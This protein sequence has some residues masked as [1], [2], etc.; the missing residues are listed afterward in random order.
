[1]RVDG[2]LY[3]DLFHR[4]KTFWS[5]ASAASHVLQTDPIPIPGVCNLLI[6][7]RP[8]HVSEQERKRRLSIE[9]GEALCEELHEPRFIRP[10]AIVV[11]SD[12]IVEHTKMAM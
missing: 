1:M 3:R 2:C 6:S 7:L 4:F 10:T 11:Q 9:G 5:V 12:Q 8:K